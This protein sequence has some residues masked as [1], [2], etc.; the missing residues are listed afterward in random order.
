MPRVL[1]YHE[2]GVVSGQR[3]DHLV[4]SGAVDGECERL[5]KARP[6]AHHDELLHAG[7][8]ARVLG[9]GALEGDAGA[10]RDLRLG[11]L[12]LIRAVRRPLDEAEVADVPR[13]R[14][15]RHV[16]AACF[17]P[18][19]QLFLARNFLAADELEDDGLPPCFH[20]HTEL[21]IIIHTSRTICCI[22]MLRDGYFLNHGRGSPRRHGQQRD[23]L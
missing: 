19:A 23:I 14:R 9:H 17:Q 3:S 13:Q 18:R 2:D 12:L 5:R 15:L 8:A 10:R 20:N 16:V 6:R 22:F 1:R 4:E 21:R 11:A 7:D